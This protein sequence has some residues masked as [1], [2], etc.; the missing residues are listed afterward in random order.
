LSA[1]IRKVPFKKVLSELKLIKIAVISQ[2]KRRR[3]WG[4][5][6]VCASPKAPRPGPNGFTS[7]L[8]QYLFFLN[9]KNR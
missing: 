9:A 7:E 4:F 1:R 2:V 5:N 8:H 6:V 3:G